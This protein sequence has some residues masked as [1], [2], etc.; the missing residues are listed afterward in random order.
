MVDADTYGGTVAQVLGLLDEAPGIAAA[1]RAAG[2]GGLDVAA[3]A[4]LTPEVGDGLRVLT[5]ISRADRWPELP[6]SSLDVV[7]QTARGLTPWVVVD[8]GF[9]LE[10]DE[11]LSYDTH[12]PGATPRRCPR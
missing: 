11:V 2:Q 4:R 7:W 8:C 5:G 3:L 1:A 6:G 12:A 9:C 10:Q